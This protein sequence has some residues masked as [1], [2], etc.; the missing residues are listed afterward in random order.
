MRTVILINVIGFLFLVCFV[1]DA[2]SDSEH[3]YKKSQAITRGYCKAQ[4]SLSKETLEEFWT[5]EL[6]QELEEVC[7]MYAS[8][9]SASSF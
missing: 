5:P 2:S 9:S 7:E 3:Y 4:E 1:L 8:I 6:V